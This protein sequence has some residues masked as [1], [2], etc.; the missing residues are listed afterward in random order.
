[1]RNGNV[2]KRDLVLIDRMAEVLDVFRVQNKYNAGKR[3]KHTKT[4]DELI[5]EFKESRH[6]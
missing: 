1:M 3:G 6:E 4:K 5:Q 2:E